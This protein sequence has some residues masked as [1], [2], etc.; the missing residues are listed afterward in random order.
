[1]VNVIQN[2]SRNRSDKKIT[3]KDLN[4]AR[5][6]AGLTYY[7]GNTH[8]AVKFIDNNNIWRVQGSFLEFYLYYV[9]GTGHNTAKVIWAFD[10]NRFYENPDHFSM[11]RFNSQSGNSIVKY[12]TSDVDSHEIYESLE[13]E[14]DQ[15]KMLLDIGIMTI[16][17]MADG[18]PV[19]NIPLSRRF[20]LWIVSPKNRASSGTNIYF[21]TV[22]IFTPKPDLF[23]ETPPQ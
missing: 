2:I 5:A 7:G 15:V 10:G 22:I 1:M 9:K 17:Q 3:I 8:Y 20:G 23:D 6:A 12:R 18:T 19:Q 21:N 11:S 14:K 13:I 16:H 4:Y